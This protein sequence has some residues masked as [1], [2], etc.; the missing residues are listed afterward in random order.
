MDRLRNNILNGNTM[1]L[2]QADGIIEKAKNVEHKLAA[3]QLKAR[4]LSTMATNFIPKELR[5]GLRDP[6]DKDILGRFFQ[7]YGVGVDENA[8]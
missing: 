2:A 5:F 3:M 1:L 7:I 4:V 8:G 6:S